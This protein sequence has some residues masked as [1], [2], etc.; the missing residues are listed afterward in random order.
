LFAEDVMLQT[1]HPEYPRWQNTLMDVIEFMLSAA[2]EKD[3]YCAVSIIL[4]PI[5]R[6][7]GSSAKSQPGSDMSSRAADVCCEAFLISQSLSNSNRDTFRQ[8]PRGLD[9]MQVAFDDMQRNAKTGRLLDWLYGHHHSI[10]FLSV[11]CAHAVAM[12]PRHRLNKLMQCVRIV[13]KE[14]KNRVNDTSRPSDADKL[15]QACDSP[16]NSAIL[17]KIYHD[18]QLGVATD[19]P[20][21]DLILSNC[22][23]ILEAKTCPVVIREQI[24][25]SL[26]HTAS[27][28]PQ[29]LSAKT[30]FRILVSLF[31]VAQKFYSLRSKRY[32]DK[33]GDDQLPADFVTYCL[34]GVIKNDLDYCDKVMAKNGS[35]AHLWCVLA[36]ILKAA[37]TADE[38]PPSSVILLRRLA[39]SMWNSSKPLQDEDVAVFEMFWRQLHDIKKTSAKHETKPLKPHDTL[40]KFACDLQQNSSFA[41]NEAMLFMLRLQKSG[42]AGNRAITLVFEKLFVAFSAPSDPRSSHVAPLCRLAMLSLLTLP[43]VL[44]SDYALPPLCAQF[45]RCPFDFGMFQSLGTPHFH[46]FKWSQHYSPSL[47]LRV[48]VLSLCDSSDRA[49]SKL[50]DELFMSLHAAI[51]S[52]LGPTNEA[53]A[54]KNM[55]MAQPF[56]L[57]EFR[58]DLVEIFQDEKSKHHDECSSCLRIHA[59][60]LKKKGFSPE[61]AR[62]L[63]TSPFDFPANTCRILCCCWC[64]LI[65][66]HGA[67]I[68]SALPSDC[69][70]LMKSILSAVALSCVQAKVCAV[71]MVVALSQHCHVAQQEDSSCSS[72]LSLLQPVVEDIAQWVDKDAVQDAAV[73]KKFTRT[74]AAPTQQLLPDDDG[75]CT[76]HRLLCACQ[77]LA[78]SSACRFAL[79]S[80]GGF[81]HDEAGKHTERRRQQRR[82]C[83]DNAYNFVVAGRYKCAALGACFRLIC[84]YFRSVSFLKIFFNI[85]FDLNSM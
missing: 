69:F 25:G 14:V 78:Y 46:D 35:F 28:E 65:A 7:L 37:Q 55:K 36:T 31:E 2:Q 9:N 29:E 72:L 76:A 34:N 74:L 52:M 32:S 62:S 21:S 47:L 49:S 84:C 51:M 73:L 75:W 57:S 63:V 39:D 42:D 30:S 16:P 8:M 4:S 64:L 26:M 77:L 3:Y 17:F 81:L 50:R 71:D 80:S 20:L 68:L 45:E 66:R 38:A 12:P 82:E 18:L 67:S 54:A 15:R 59:V 61:E 22:C 23:D 43:R 44:L 24:L 19:K 58:K 85:R 70:H 48:L 56:K 41:A 27:A 40:R 10:D 11:L 53:A 5:I 6:F 79:Q 1:D 83:F 60:H 33:L 13:L